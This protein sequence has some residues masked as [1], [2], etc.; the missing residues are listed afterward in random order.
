MRTILCQLLLTVDVVPEWARVFCADVTDLGIDDHDHEPGRQTWIA[1]LL[2]R[3]HNPPV[4]AQCSAW[5]W[6]SQLLSFRTTAGQLM[7]QRKGSIHWGHACRHQ[8][9]QAGLQADLM[10]A[11]HER[12]A[13]GALQASSAS[14]DSSNTAFLPCL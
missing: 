5:P 13:N 9:A 3:G 11:T 10:D 4:A 14:S 8:A 6:Q 7:Q 1:G 2:Q 12:P